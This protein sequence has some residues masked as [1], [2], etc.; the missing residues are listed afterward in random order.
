MAHS[1]EDAIADVRNAT[2]ISEKK[3]ERN[4]MKAA[5][6]PGDLNSFL[7]HYKYQPEL[8]ARLDGLDVTSLDQSLVNDIVLWKVNRYVKVSEEI[9]S[10]ISGVKSLKEKEHRK[11]K[12][13]LSVL[14]KLNGVDLPM[15]S[16]ILRFI[17]PQVFQI[18]DRHAYRAIYETKYP[19][20]P[21]TSSERKITVYFDYIDELIKLCELKGLSFP[22]I[23]RLLYIFDKNKNGQL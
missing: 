3:P 5:D 22:T 14:L 12:G 16:T 9:I 17:N 18:I 6:F 23:D 7:N 4:A 10:Q 13:V 19:L 21:T 8:T 1:K 11:S 15:A 2:E 20:Y